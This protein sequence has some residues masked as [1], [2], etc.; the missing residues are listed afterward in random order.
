MPSGLLAIHNDPI[1]HAKMGVCERCSENMLKDLLT[2]IEEEIPIR[3]TTT[4]FRMDWNLSERG[5]PDFGGIYAFWWR[6]SA[7]HFVDSIQ[8]PKLHFHGPGGNPLSYKI[9]RAGLTLADNGRLPLYVGKAYSSIA[10]RIGQHMTLGTPRS[11]PQ[12][13]CYGVAGRRTTSCQVRDRLDRLYPYVEDMRAIAIANLSISY[14]RLDE[15]GDF[16]SR[17]FLEDLAIGK[18]RPLFNLDSER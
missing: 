2:I 4:S 17:F 10:K 16:V 1:E 9:D 18:L 14:V 5:K 15:E 3:Q 12:D 6:H 11:V 7:E 13:Q 8:N